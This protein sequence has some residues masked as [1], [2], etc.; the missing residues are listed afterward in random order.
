[1]DVGKSKGGTMGLTYPMLI[2][3]NYTA[4]SLKMKAFM[5]AH[6][7]WDAV[8]PSNPK[9]TADERTDKIALVMIYQSIPEEI[10]L[11]LAEK[12]KAKDA[13]VEIKTMTQGAERLKA[14]KVQNLTSEFE[15]LSMNNT[16]FLDDFSIK[17]TGLVTKICAIGEDMK[18]A[19]VVKK[20]LCAMRAKFLQIMSTME[21]FGDLE[22]ITVEEVV[23]SLKAHEERLNGQVENSEGQL[24]L[25]EE[26]WA[27]KENENGKLLLTKELWQRRVNKGGTDAR[28]RVGRD[29]SR[30]KCYNCN[31]YGHY[32]A[33]YR[34]PRRPREVKQESRQE[35]HLSQT[36]D[37]KPALLLAKHD[38]GD[39][40]VMLN[41]IGVTPKL[42]TGASETGEGSNVWYLDNGAS[43]HMTGDKSK[44]KKL[45]STISGCVKFGDGSAV[46]I[47]GKG[48]IVFKC[49]NGEER[50]LQEV[51]YIPTLHNN[52]IS[53]RQLSETGNKV[54]LSGNYLWV[55]EQQ[56][57]LLI[58]VKKSHNRL[59]KLLVETIKPVCLL[60]KT[61]EDTRL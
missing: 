59:Y 48:S 36:E 37:D 18:E 22:T 16:E 38:K 14:A 43:N 56:G 26:E 11:S 17:L 41:E 4:W 20:P 7:V 52:I 21:Q 3:M 27:K 19:Y 8:E 45:D 50:I 42:N 31:I 5:E 29:K 44:F 60:S 13:W 34:K 40:V 47:E 54:V 55:Y 30:K 53:L 39:E 46:Q 58:K 23:G 1:M 2:K 51:Y 33:E 49:R 10:L 57:N 25:I 61:K 6:G 12:K 35:A 24:M 32:V 9:G 28:N 15:S